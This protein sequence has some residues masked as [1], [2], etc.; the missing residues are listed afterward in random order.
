VD[1][2]YS[3]DQRLLR[4]SVDRMLADRYSFEARARYAGGAEGWSRP[5][6]REFGEMG[7]LALPFAADQ[8]GLGLGAVETMI[9]GEAFGRHLVVEPYLA[10]IV[11]AGTALHL[12]AAPL[13]GLVTGERIAALAD[14][15]EVTASRE[16]A[17]WALSG[18]ATLVLDGDSAD[19]LVVP[20][21]DQLFVVPAD[22][23]GLARRCFRLHG[24]GGAADISLDR[25]LLPPEALL[26]GEGILDRAIEAGIAFLSAEAVGASRSALDMTVDHLK[27]REQFGKPIGANQ[28]LQH[29]AAEMLVE[30]EQLQSAALYAALL[31]DEPDDLARARGF[32]AVK[33]VVGKSSSFVAQQAVHLHGGIGVSEEHIVSH[34][35]RRLTG[36][37][38]LLGDTGAQVRRL[39]A[40]GGFTGLEP[41]GA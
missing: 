27:T 40:L 8:G 32:A 29:R 35:F 28:A 16:G 20:A 37:S 13:H 14:Q 5:M 25:I 36:I 7:L 12:G 9:V 3:D 33:A 1:F 34:Y 11:L 15:A 31:G 4:E 18:R 26:A 6:W 30:V 23:P 10:S 21:G 19:L 38:M 41:H 39:A 2:A 24:G 17:G 22:S